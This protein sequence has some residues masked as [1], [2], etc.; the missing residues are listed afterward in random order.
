LRSATR[1]AFLGED[2][3]IV[4]YHFYQPDLETYRDRVHLFHPAPCADAGISQGLAK[5][6]EDYQPTCKGLNFSHQCWL[7]N[8]FALYKSA[9]PTLES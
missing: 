9:L 7:Y 8:L 3:F 6:V 2:R 1:L 4:G 5:D